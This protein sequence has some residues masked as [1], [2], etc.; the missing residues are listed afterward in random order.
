MLP[1]AHLTSHSRMSGSRWVI[2]PSWF[3]CVHVPQLSYPFIGHWTSM[4]LPCPGYC[5]Q[6]CNE[7]W[8]TRVSFNSGFLSVY[9][10]LWWTLGYMCLF[11][12]WFP[13]CVYP[14]VQLLGRMAVLFT[15]FFKGIST[16]F[17]IV[18]ILVC[19]PTNSARGFPFLHT[20]SR[21]Y[22]LQTFW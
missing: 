3:H 22:C 12:F 11:S 10:Q 14:A 9:A 16:L 19:I 20:L 17:S 4:L 15:V 7:H 18:A 1:K 13:R 21:I 5:K 8:G 6:R 2:R